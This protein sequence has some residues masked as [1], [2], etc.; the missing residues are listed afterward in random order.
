MKLFWTRETSRQISG[1]EIAAA[2]LAT[3]CHSVAI[4]RVHRSQPDV[5]DV[6]D[7]V[8]ERVALDRLAAGG[9]DQPLDLARSSS[10]PASREPA[11]W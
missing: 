11:M 9:A 4:R 1:C 7:D 5:A 8:V 2:D 10:P 6:R 3:L